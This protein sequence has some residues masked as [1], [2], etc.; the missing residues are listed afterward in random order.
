M[1]LASLPVSLS[2]RYCGGGAP[3]TCSWSGSGSDFTPQP[4]CSDFDTSCRLRHGEGKLS[5]CRSK[6]SEPVLGT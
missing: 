2:A 5:R 3:V 1:T 4:V 6:R